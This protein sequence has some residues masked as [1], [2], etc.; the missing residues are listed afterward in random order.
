MLPFRAAVLA[1]LA[2]LALRPGKG[3]LR[4]KAA[5][6]EAAAA[7]FLESGFKGDPPGVPWDGTPAAT[8]SFLRSASSKQSL[9]GLAGVGL[10]EPAI[11]T[12]IQGKVFQPEPG[13][14]PATGQQPLA[15][16]SLLSAA[17]GSRGPPT[18]TAG[19]VAIASLPGRSAGAATPLAQ[20]SA[21]SQPTSN[22]CVDCL[23][24]Q[25]CQP[26]ACLPIPLHAACCARAQQAAA[27]ILAALF[28]VSAHLSP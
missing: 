16:P 12:F 23:A 14:L 15:P 13:A 28:P 11:D 3:W 10:T 17:S 21:F 4:R 24:S 7:E 6:G 22:R 25:R 20:H 18:P 5:V 27:R 1:V 2:F 26:L 19:A 8:D 9:P